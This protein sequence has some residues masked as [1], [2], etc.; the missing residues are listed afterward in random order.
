M[1]VVVE[2]FLGCLLF[3]IRLKEQHWVEAPGDLLVDKS[4][5]EVGD[6]EVVGVSDF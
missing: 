1:K 5:A 4:L 2:F 3:V 6:L